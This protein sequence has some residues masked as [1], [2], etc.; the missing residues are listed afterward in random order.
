[1]FIDVGDV[2]SYVGVN[3]FRDDE[4]VNGFFF[5]VYNFE[6]VIVLSLLVNFVIVY[7]LRVCGGCNLGTSELEGLR[8]GLIFSCFF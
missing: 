8:V 5:Y 6:V 7:L 1:M 2:F 3:G 4:C